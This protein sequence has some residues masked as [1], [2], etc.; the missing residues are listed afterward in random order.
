MIFSVSG[1]GYL[2]PDGDCVIGGGVDRVSHT[3][4]NERFTLPSTGS[5]QLLLDLC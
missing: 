2:T 3:A 1:D 4:N 5:A